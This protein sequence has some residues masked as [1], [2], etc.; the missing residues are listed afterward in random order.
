MEEP[1][2][3]VPAAGAGWGVSRLWLFV[4][5]VFLFLAVASYWIPVS[6]HFPGTTYRSPAVRYLRLPTWDTL[7]LLWMERGIRLKLMVVIACLIATLGAAIVDFISLQRRMYRVLCILTAVS[8]GLSLWVMHDIYH[9]RWIVMDGDTAPGVILAWFATVMA[10]IGL[11]VAYY[12]PRK[13]QT[14][15]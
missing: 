3:Q 1:L 2:Y 8:C 7:D 5:I 6:G 13:R 11:L 15:S 14:N 9:M 10:C 12:Q 4:V